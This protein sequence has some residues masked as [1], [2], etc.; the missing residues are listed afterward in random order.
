MIPDPDYWIAA[1]AVQHRIRLVTTDAHFEHF[2]EL[3]PWLVR[4]SA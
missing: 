3:Q 4:V 1:L 2:D